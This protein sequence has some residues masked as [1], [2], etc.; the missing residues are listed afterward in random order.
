MIANLQTQRARLLDR[1]R[2]HEKNIRERSAVGMRAT[3]SVRAAERR[4]AEIAALDRAIE[5]KNEMMTSE[6]LPPAAGWQLRAKRS[7]TSGGTFFPRGATVPLGEIE[8]AANVAALFSD[9]LTWCPP[10]SPPGPQPRP[11]VAAA[12]PKRPSKDQVAKLLAEPRPGDAVEAWKQLFGGMMRLTNNNPSLSEDILLSDPAASRLAQHAV[13]IDA[14][15]RGQGSYRR[16]VR[17][18]REIAAA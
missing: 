5:G 4:R 3:V 1:L 16:V 6:M 7:F 12:A 14:E 8:R 11:V 2:W 15:R 17:P 18:L 9:N 13:R 10:G